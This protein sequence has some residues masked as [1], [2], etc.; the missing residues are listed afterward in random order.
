[1]ENNQIE[2]IIHLATIYGRNNE[3]IS[4]IIDTN[5]NLPLKLLEYASPYKIKF[6][7]NTDTFYESKMNFINKLQYYTLSKEQFKT[8]GKK[9]ARENGISF[10]NVKLFMFMELKTVLQNLY[11]N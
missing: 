2:G 8:Y 6:F 1:M 4:Q 5:L 7:L 11:R 3:T 9:L 10:I